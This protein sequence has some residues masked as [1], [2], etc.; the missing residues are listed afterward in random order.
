MS[1]VSV[2]FCQV[3]LPT[4]GRSLVQRSPTDNGVSE[5]DREAAIIKRGGLYGAVEP[6]VENYVYRY[7]SLPLPHIQGYSKR[8]LVF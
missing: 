2:V 3:E 8:S 5:C 1:L 6:C 4:T 7:S